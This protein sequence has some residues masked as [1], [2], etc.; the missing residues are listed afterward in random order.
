MRTHLWCRPK[1]CTACHDCEA[2]CVLIHNPDWKT[3]KEV[4]VEAGDQEKVK[5]LLGSQATSEQVKAFAALREII[6]EKGKTP[7]VPLLEV[8]EQ[9]GQNYALTCR[10]C[11][12]PKCVKACWMKVIRTS[13][14]GVV[15]EPET[16]EKCIGCTLCG[17]ACAFGIPRFNKQGKMVKCDLCVDRLREGKEPACVAVCSQKALLFK[18]LRTV[19]APKPQGNQEIG[20]GI[21]ELWHNNKSN[22][23][24]MLRFRGNGGG[25]WSAEQLDVICKWAD[26]LVESEEYQAGYLDITLRQDIELHHLQFSS[27]EEKAEFFEDLRQAN[28]YLGNFGPLFRNIV[29]CVGASCSK[30]RGDAKGLGHALYQ[31]LNEVG[32]NLPKLKGK[33]K[34]GLSGCLEGC[35][36]MRMY[37]ITVAALKEGEV[38]GLEVEALSSIETPSLY[39]VFL[40]G[41][42]GRFPQPGVKVAD[43]DSQ[44]QVIDFIVK[45]AEFFKDYCELGN[46]HRLSYW[47][48]VKYGK[49]GDP[50]IFS[51]D[52]IS[53][54]LKDFS[55]W[56]EKKYGSL[57]WL[58]KLSLEDPIPQSVLNFIEYHQKK[59]TPMDI[60]KREDVFPHLKV[61]G[62]E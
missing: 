48:R 49:T 44:D 21:R 45:V 32:F 4:K 58:S 34:V 60:Y 30:S 59:L 62:A 2:A 19:Y 8:I 53:E 40:G 25:Y 28:I 11:E 37:D 1:L 31:K 36:H 7:T 57:G 39:R 50:F 35:G 13:S 27:E 56:V 24:Y 42:M 38:E 46:I 15:Q 14:E 33:I 43:F 26:K 55:R 22:P 23:E 16:G 52:G 9:E 6:K 12:D 54:F 41:N 5:K 3:D 29:S 10:H 47:I 51:V 18:D 61:E 17:S 20:F